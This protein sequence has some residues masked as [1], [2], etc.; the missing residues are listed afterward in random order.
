MYNCGSGSDCVS[1]FG[2]LWIQPPL[3]IDPITYQKCYILVLPALFWGES[4]KSIE[5]IL[6]LPAPLWVREI[7]V[8]FGLWTFITFFTYTPSLFQASLVMTIHG[9]LHLYSSLLMAIHGFH[10]YSCQLVVDADIFFYA[11]GWK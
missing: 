4:N 9:F 5:E 8:Q 10:L 7:L 11:S 1:Q 3:L 6:V 2:D